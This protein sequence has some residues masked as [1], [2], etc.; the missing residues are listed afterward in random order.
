MIKLIPP[1]RTND[2]HGSGYYGAPRGSRTHKGIDLNAIPDSMVLS[3]TTGVVTKIGYPYSDDL[4][5]KYVQITT[6]DNNDFR[7]FY[8]KPSVHKGQIIQEGDIIGTV[9][10]LT[11]RYPGIS[12]H[13]HF[14]VKVNGEH[15][16]PEP[17][18]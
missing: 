16:D 18:L 15:V 13:L 2:K 9:Q 17:F 11:T 3:N 6:E 1:Q 4:S 5:Y 8:V 12:N 7:Y 14:E 10:D